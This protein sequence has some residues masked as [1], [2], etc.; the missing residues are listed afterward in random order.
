MNCPHCSGDLKFQRYTTPK[1][2][3]TIVGPIKYSRAYY[4]CKKCGHSWFPMDD[5]FAL[6]HKQTPG[7]AQLASLAG[8][9]TPFQQA[10]ERALLSMSGLRVSESPIQ[11]TSARKLTR[12]SGRGMPSRRRTPGNGIW[13]R[14]E[15]VALT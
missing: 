10:A 9:L 14:M 11:R 4:W 1:N 3:L 6:L 15:S 8:S 5:E 13:M 12:H 7:V 2:M